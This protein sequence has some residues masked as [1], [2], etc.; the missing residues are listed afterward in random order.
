MSVVRCSSPSLCGNPMPPRITR[1]SY[2]PRVT[3]R[4]MV[5]TNNRY[6]CQLQNRFGV[7]AAKNE[8][9]R[10]SENETKTPTQSSS[11][12]PSGLDVANLICVPGQRKKVSVLDISDSRCIVPFLL[13]ALAR[14]AT[15]ELV[16]AS[17]THLFSVRPFA[18][19]S[20]NC[21]SSRRISASCQH[22]CIT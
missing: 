4:T 20:Y 18:R 22:S 1:K 2:R 6:A 15:T 3:D 7:V 14:T 9:V 12:L 10:R 19:T 21:R 13:P 17:T 11:S 16:I 5:D 8:D